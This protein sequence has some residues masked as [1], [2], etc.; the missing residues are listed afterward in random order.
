MASLDEILT[1]V[2]HIIADFIMRQLETQEFIRKLY[3]GYCFFFFLLVTLKKNC[4]ADD[5]R[6]RQLLGNTL[7]KGVIQPGIVEK[8]GRYTREL[9]MSL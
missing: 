5:Y 6:I 2:Q 7:Q 8:L 9:K 1:G 4:F 3:V